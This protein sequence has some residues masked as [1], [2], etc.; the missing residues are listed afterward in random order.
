MAELKSE[1]RKNYALTKKKVWQ[2]W[3]L[4]LKLFYKWPFF[5]RARLTEDRAF[6]LKR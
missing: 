6:T 3:L 1:K 4:T 5:V 2:D